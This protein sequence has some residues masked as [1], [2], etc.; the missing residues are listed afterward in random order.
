MARYS[1]FLTNYSLLPFCLCLLLNHFLFL[2]GNQQFCLLTLP[3]G[4]E[5]KT[6][7]TLFYHRSTTEIPLH[8]AQTSTQV[9]GVKRKVLWN[10][11]AKHIHCTCIHVS[12]KCL[13]WSDCFTILSV[14]DASLVG[15]MAVSS[16]IC[17]QSHPQ[18]PLAWTSPLIIIVLLLTWPCYL[19]QNRESLC[20]KNL[21]YQW[22]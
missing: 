2:L 15:S 18:N 1:A 9:H 20:V 6:F 7:L 12:K 13:L 5:N 17:R 21:F 16:L 14:S 22:S 19:L 4:Q 10:T 8:W 11:T 3:D